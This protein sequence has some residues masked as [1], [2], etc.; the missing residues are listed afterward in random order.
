[1]WMRWEC[2]LSLL[3]IRDMITMSWV[4][5]QVGYDRYRRRGDIGE[6]ERR[7]KEKGSKKF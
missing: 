3:M 4:G 5:E 7:E 6:K 1:M 2:V